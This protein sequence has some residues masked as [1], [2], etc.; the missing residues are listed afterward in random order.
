MINKSAK[1]NFLIVS[2]PSF[3][4]FNTE[5][6]EILHGVSGEFKSGKLVAIIGP[7]GAGKLTLLNVLAGYT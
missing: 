7:S 5:E 3:I 2:F 6:K 1:Y 4:F